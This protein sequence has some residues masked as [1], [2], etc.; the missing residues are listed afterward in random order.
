MMT[1]MRNSILLLTIATLTLTVVSGQIVKGH[2]NNDNQPGQSRHDGKRAMDSM[3]K[4]MMESFKTSFVPGSKKDDG[5]NSD[6]SPSDWKNMIPGFAKGFIPDSAEGDTDN[7]TISED[8]TADT[9][10]TN[11]T[12]VGIEGSFKV[13]AGI[14]D[15]ES[16]MDDKMTSQD[17]GSPDSTALP[18]ALPTDDNVPSEYGLLMGDTNGAGD[19]GETSETTAEV[20]AKPKNDETDMMQPERE[21]AEAQNDKASL[22]NDMGEN[23]ESVDTM[24]TKQDPDAEAKK[25]MFLKVAMSGKA[26]LKQDKKTLAQADTETSKETTI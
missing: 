18:D 23:D 22:T 12:S 19:D 9:S 11:S 14:K 15:D 17:G 13:N 10:A 20:A 3:Y 5:G 21:A 25:S 26:A 2:G 6:A 8:T 4:G 24:K 7:S 16:N 1:G